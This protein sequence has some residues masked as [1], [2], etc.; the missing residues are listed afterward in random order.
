MRDAPDTGLG[1]RSLAALVEGGAL[2][3]R[4]P[5]FRPREAQQV[6]ACAVA[7][8]IDRRSTLLAEAGTGTR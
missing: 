7:D 5:A 3:E 6:L 1:A 2:A 4:I 8:A